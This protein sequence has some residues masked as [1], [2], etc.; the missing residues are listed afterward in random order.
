[1]T[2]ARRKDLGLYGC[3]PTP[4]AAY[5]LSWS[6]ETDRW[7]IEN[8]LESFVPR[9]ARVKAQDRQ[10]RGRMRRL[11]QA[12]TRARRGWLSRHIRADLRQR[13]AAMEDLERKYVRWRAGLFGKQ[14]RSEGKIKKLRRIILS[15]RHKGEAVQYRAELLMYREGTRDTPPPRPAHRAINRR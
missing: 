7:R 3:A 11:R 15:L 4:G 8:L 2:C 12:K 14:I 13:Q 6:P 5:G 10:L 9:V 1:V